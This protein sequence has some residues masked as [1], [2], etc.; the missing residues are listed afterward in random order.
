[1]TRRPAPHSYRRL[2][3]TLLMASLAAS[4]AGAHLLAWQ[5]S[6]LA[7]ASAPGSPPP[8]TRLT[9]PAGGAGAGEIVLDLAPVPTV[10]APAHQA[11]IRPVART[12]SS[13]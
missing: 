1:M 10:V 5:E 4:L 7:D 12:R 3:L 11:A 9:I 8:A 13:R 2:K 6:L